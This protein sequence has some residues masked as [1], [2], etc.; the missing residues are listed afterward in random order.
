[1]RKW[2]ERVTTKETAKDLLLFLIENDIEYEATE[3][4]DECRVEFRAD[5]YEVSEIDAFIE[6]VI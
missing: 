1:M 4:V 3:C 6:S 2:N 5:A